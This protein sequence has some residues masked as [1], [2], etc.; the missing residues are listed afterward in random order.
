MNGIEAMSTVTQV[1]R[2]LGVK[3]Q[4]DGLD[5]VLVAVEASGPGFAPEA[6]DRLFEAFFTAKPS[7]MGRRGAARNRE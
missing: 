6:A 1:P 5:N 7:G 2:I 4:L 3:S